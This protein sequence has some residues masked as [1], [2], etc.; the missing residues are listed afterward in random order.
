LRH[1]DEKKLQLGGW[2]LSEF[3]TPKVEEDEGFEDF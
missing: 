1:F 3:G 2:A